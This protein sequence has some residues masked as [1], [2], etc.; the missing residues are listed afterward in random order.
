M[1]CKNAEHWMALAVGEDLSPTEGLDLQR[2]LQE[3]SKCQQA[4]EQHQRGFAALQQSRTHEAR[5]KSDSIWPGVAHRLRARDSAPERGEFNGWIAAL[6][7]TAACVL[8][9]VFSQDDARS[10]AVQQGGSSNSTM[11]SS[12]RNFDAPTLRPLR[13]DDLRG[14]APYNPQPR[15]DRK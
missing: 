6:A 8:L 14:Q 4:W 9:F 1:K 11:V 10:I 7:V 13:P 15:S 2:H 5:P 3:C 12:P